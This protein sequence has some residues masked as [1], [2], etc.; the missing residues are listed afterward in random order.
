MLARVDTVIT[1]PFKAESEQEQV[2]LMNDNDSD[3]NEENGSFYNPCE[4]R[5]ISDFGDSI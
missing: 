1:E 5:K 4:P 2:K 3:K